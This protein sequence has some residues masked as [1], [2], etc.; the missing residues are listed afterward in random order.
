MQG[1]GMQIRA[2][3]LTPTQLS[4]HHPKHLAQVHCNVAQEFHM[5]QIH[6]RLDEQEEGQ[7]REGVVKLADAN[8]L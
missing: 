1:V 3:V 7:T 4:K 6:H 2:V 8:L 5:H